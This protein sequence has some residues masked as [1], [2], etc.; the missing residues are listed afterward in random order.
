MQ[1]QIIMAIQEQL[2]IVPV[3]SSHQ[4]MFAIINLIQSHVLLQKS[5]CILSYKLNT[6][7]KNSNTY[8]YNEAMIKKQVG[9][10]MK[11]CMC[12][13]DDLSNNTIITYNKNDHSYCMGA[14]NVQDDFPCD[15]REH[16]SEYKKIEYVTIYNVNKNKQRVDLCRY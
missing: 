3:I 15:I 6:L 10:H 5:A 8:N 14:M 9:E 12:C 2:D 13:R 1:H 11:F 7:K 16:F 4:K